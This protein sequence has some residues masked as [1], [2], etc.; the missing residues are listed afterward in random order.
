M[1]RKRILAPWLLW[2]ALAAGA[3]LGLMAGSRPTL[4]IEQQARKIWETR[5]L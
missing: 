1:T 3:I 5:F 2:L 4:S